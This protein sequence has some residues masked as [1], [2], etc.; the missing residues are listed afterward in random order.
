M[1]DQTKYPNY[2]LFCSTPIILIIQRATQSILWEKFREK[3]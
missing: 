2:K 1:L 3:I